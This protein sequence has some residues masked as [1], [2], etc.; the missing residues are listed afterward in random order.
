MSEENRT[1]PLLIIADRAP[2]T[3]KVQCNEL[4][5]GYM[6]INASGFDRK[7]HKKYVEK[8]KGE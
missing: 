8:E 7:V 3:V 4:E 6:I 2:E 1:D 5:S